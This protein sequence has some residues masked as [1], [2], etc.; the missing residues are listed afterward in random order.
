MLKH[1]LRLFDAAVSPTVCYAAG[2]WTPNKEHERMIQSTQRKMLGL[3]I[4]TRRKY[5]K[6][7]KKDIGTNEE[8][9]EIDINEMCSTDESGDGMSTTTHN[10]VD[11]EVSFEDDADDE[12]DTTLIEEEDWIEYIKR[13]TD[14]AMEKMESAKIRCWKETHKIMKWKLALRIATSPSERWLKKAAEWNP[15]LSSR[16]RT[17]RA[18]GRSRKRWEDDINEFLKQEFEETENPF[19]SSNQT[20]KTWINLAKD[21]RRWALTQ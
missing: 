20:N 16:Y 18:I 17:N 14:E 4:Q 8:I 5:T 19:E 1:R 15:E 6:I 21:R 10:D 7:E 11:S 13:S 2:T 9:D 3:I 12:I